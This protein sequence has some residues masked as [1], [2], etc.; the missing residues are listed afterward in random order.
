MDRSRLGSKIRPTPHI[1]LTQT[2]QTSTAR[3]ADRAAT[4]AHR[5]RPAATHRVVSSA[6]VRGARP[7]CLDPATASPATPPDL[8]PTA[9]A[10]ARCAASRYACAAR[11]FR[12]GV[13]GDLFEGKG[14]FD[15]VREGLRYRIVHLSELEFRLRNSGNPVS[16]FLVLFHQSK[17]ISQTKFESKHFIFS[18][19]A[20]M[21]DRTSEKVQISQHFFHCTAAVEYTT[22]DIPVVF[23]NF[24]KFAKSCEVDR[25]I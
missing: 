23:Y 12:G 15:E 7:G 10:P 24:A 2:A 17:P 4:R 22:K 13:E 18:Q 20:A 3:L 11:S 19:R 25:F 16:M 5:F 14:G 8:P 6:G 1:Q 21:S 9:A